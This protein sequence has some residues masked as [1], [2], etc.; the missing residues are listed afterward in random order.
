[1]AF[2]KFANAEVLDI[3]GSTVPGR[4]L[5][6]LRH[7]SDFDNYRTGDGYMYVRI[8][9]ISSRTNKNN[10][11]WPTVELAGGPE[12]WEKMTSKHTSG[13][14]FT[15]ESSKGDEYGF[16]TFLG[17]PIFVDHN[18]HDPKRARGVIVDSKFHVLDHK[19]ASED[20]YWNGDADPEHLPASEVE[21]LLEVDAK[22]FPKLAKAISDGDIDGFSMGCDVER[23]RCSHCKHEASSPEEYCN[24]IQMKG[25]NFTYSDDKGRTSSR[26]SYENCYGIKF[27]EISAVFEPADETALAREVIEEMPTKLANPQG[28]PSGGAQGLPQFNAPDP[29]IVR[30]RYLKNRE[31]GLDDA[32]ALELAERTVLQQKQQQGD[33]IAPA[34]QDMPQMDIAPRVYDYHQNIPK[35]MYMGPLNPTGDPEMYSNDPRWSSMQKTAEPDLPDSMMTKGPEDVDTLRTERVCPICGSDMEKDKCDV[36]GYEAPPESLENPDLD[37]AKETDLSEDLPT[38]APP[39]SPEAPETPPEGKQEGSLLTNNP[40]TTSSV[41]SS[42]RSWTPRIYGGSIIDPVITTSNSTARVTL[43]NV[44]K[45][46][47]DEPPKETVISDQTAPVTSAFRTAQDLIEAAKKRNPIQ[48]NQMSDHEKVAAEPVPAAKPDKRVNVEGVGG[49]IQDTNAE[50]SKPEGAHSWENKGVTVDVTGKG[51]VLE[52]SNADASKPSQGTESLPDGDQDNAGFQDGGVTKGPNTKTFPNSNE[53]GSAVTDKAFPVSHTEA[54]KQGVKPLKTGEPFDVQPSARVNVESDE[55]W[56]T[57]GTETDQWTGTDGNGVTRQQNP[58]TNVPTKSQ[59]IKSHVSIAALKLADQEVELGLIDRDDKYDRLAELAELSDEE[60]A[61]EARVTARVKKAG[62]AKHAAQ[63]PR[64]LPS[65]R[66]ATVEEPREAI[67]ITDDMLDSAI[68]TR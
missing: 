62:L 22:N 59:G 60:L 41:K 56:N 12:S 47:G 17:K 68:F 57:N 44:D 3:K 66:H 40:Q 18:N 23:S 7:L 64:R 63:Q 14:G 24:H 11:G 10:D 30:D 1:M 33:F 51:G 36:C 16:S 65:F 29:N 39:D 6:S 34:G 4:N 19:T 38:D 45:P 48:G 43:A 61:A 15:V 31:M 50:A 13:E 35:N 2:T 32:T 67:S 37:K 25:K 54:A 46:S 49:V 52:D 8:R 9:A 28:L 58:V 21:L 42:M 53:P 26:K 27:F 55:F 5:A 20:D